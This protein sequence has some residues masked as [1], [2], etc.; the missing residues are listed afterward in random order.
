MG[1]SNRVL[2]AN[3]CLDVL[4]DGVSI[5]DHSIDLIYLDPPFNSKSKYNLPFKGEYV[6]DLRPVMAFKDT[7]T[8]SD[9]EQDELE[10][11]RHADAI[12]RT[13]ADI[14]ELARRVYNERPNS[15][16]SMGAYLL[17]MAVRLKPMKR[18]LRDTGSIYLHC[19]Q[20]AS[21]YLKLIMDAIFGTSNFRNEIVWSYHRWTGATERFQRMHDVLLFYGKSK[22]VTFNELMEDYSPKSQHK[23][24]RHSIHE[25]GKLEQ[26]YTDDTSRKKAMRDVWDISVLNSQANERL[27]YP[28]QKPLSL[29]ERVIRASTNEGDVVCDPFCGCGSGVHAAENLNRNWIGI[30]ISQFAVE[31]IRNRILNNFQELTA[32]DIITLG[33]PRTTQEAQ[34]LFKSSHFEFEKWACGA[35][36]AE[37][38]FHRPGTKGPDGGVD[39]VI[40]FY[41]QREFN[42]KDKAEK[43]YAIVQV[44]GGKV[45]PDNVRG[46]STVVRQTNAKCGV[47]ICFDRYMQTVENNREKGTITDALGD[48]PFIQGF[49]VERL[50]SGDRPNLPVFAKAA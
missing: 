47:F 48:F 34:Q 21:H 50:I 40:P 36:G 45:S 25:D 29:I 3:D 49:S 31:L 35:V 46:L 26:T 20:T 11:L 12:G 8:W 7:W 19:D 13:L 37:G 16:V 30:D 42:L 15:K 5:P 33:V 23:A 24:A 44:K 4:E 1:L 38:M 10:K 28:T 32:D 39:G 41:H 14:V 2:Y 6:K 43:T 9:F 27:G 17:N 18:T 22:A